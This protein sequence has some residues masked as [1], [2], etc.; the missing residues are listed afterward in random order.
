MEKIDKMR[1]VAG[2]IAQKFF[3]EHI[4]TLAEDLS[5]RELLLRLF[6]EYEFYEEGEKL[7]E[8]DCFD[9]SETNNGF[10]I[11]KLPWRNPSFVFSHTAQLISS[12]RFG[13]SVLTGIISSSGGLT[14]STLKASSDVLVRHLAQISK[15]EGGTKLKIEFLAHFNSIFKEN[16]K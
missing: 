11:N 13:R 2:R 14:E 9:D 10:Y 8:E 3:K 6:V 15:T 1:E 5:D 7:I 16:L 4:E 12:K